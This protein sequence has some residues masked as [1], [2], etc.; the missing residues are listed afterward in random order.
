VS[1]HR[2]VV[3]RLN[4]FVADL[5]REMRRHLALAILDTAKLSGSGAQQRLYMREPFLDRLEAPSQ[6][7][8]HT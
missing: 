6:V 7:G 4:E 1:G 8:R 2:H 5:H 3:I